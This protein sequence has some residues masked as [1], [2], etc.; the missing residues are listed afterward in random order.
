MAVAFGQRVEVQQGES[1]VLV[2]AASEVLYAFQDNGGLGPEEFS[3]LLCRLH[4]EYYSILCWLPM[5]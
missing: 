5:R 2:K 4:S 1:S 3:M